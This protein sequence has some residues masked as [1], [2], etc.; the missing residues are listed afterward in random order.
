[1]QVSKPG[2]S[3]CC[4]FSFTSLDWRFITFNSIPIILIFSTIKNPRHRLTVDHGTIVFHYRPC[5]TMVGDGMTVLCD[6]GVWPWCVISSWPWYI[7]LQPIYSVTISEQKP[8]DCV[9]LG[10]RLPTLKAAPFI[11][12]VFRLSQSASSSSLCTEVPPHSGKIDFSYGRGTSVHR[13]L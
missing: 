8:R 6:H 3:L 10:M 12:A 4:M 5:L 9:P 11:F 1:M 2:L 13:L 7:T